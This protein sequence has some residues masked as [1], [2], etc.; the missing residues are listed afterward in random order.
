MLTAM[1]DKTRLIFI[2]NPNNP[3]GTYLTEQALSKFLAAVPEQV[4]V[5]LDEAYFEYVSKED[6]FSA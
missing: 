5:V 2:A 1:T 6:S 3:T 4:I